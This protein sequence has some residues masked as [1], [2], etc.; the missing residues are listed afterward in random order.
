M[1]TL[2][3]DLEQGAVQVRTPDEFLAMPEDYQEVAKRQM[4]VHTEGELSGADDYIQVFYGLAP[5][6]EEQQVCCERAVEELNHYKIGSSVLAGI[7]VDTSYM[8][9]QEL[10]DR[11]LFAEAELHRITTWAERG[12]FSFVGEDAVMEHLLEMAQSSY[13]PWAESFRTIIADE[14][15]HIGHGARIVRGL[16]QSEEGREQVQ[17]ALDKLWPQFVALFGH[18]ESERSRLSVKY[19][20]RKRSNRQ[21]RDEWMQRM[22]PKLAGLGL[23]VPS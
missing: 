6:A 9:Q 20:L 11:E 17:A 3:L 2:E 22:V 4:L 13:H 23:T 7:G 8:E 5:T 15:V 1:A 12:V 16:L 19:G 10:Q 14:K 21:A 18:P